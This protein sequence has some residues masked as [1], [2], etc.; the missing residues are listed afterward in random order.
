MPGFISLRPFQRT[1]D[2][3]SW[4]KIPKGIVNFL[5]IWAP[6]PEARPSVRIPVLLVIG[7][8]TSGKLFNLCLSFLVYKTEV[9]VLSTYCI[10]ATVLNAFLR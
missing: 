4:G 7:S 1:P 5:W 9:I 8:V 10:P 6:E 3:V 2:L